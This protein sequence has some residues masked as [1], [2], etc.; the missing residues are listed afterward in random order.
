MA[1]SK[2]VKA[3]N[4]SDIPCWHLLQHVNVGR[5]T[6]GRAYQKVISFFVPCFTLSAVYGKI[7]L[8]SSEMPVKTVGQLVINGIFGG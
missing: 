3:Y 1:S 6:G 2:L 8:V 5:S 4:F 7:I